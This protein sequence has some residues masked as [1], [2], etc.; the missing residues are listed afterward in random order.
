MSA[1]PVE[2]TPGACEP[3]AEAVL[4]RGG[5]ARSAA[6]PPG[7][8]ADAADAVEQVAGYLLRYGVILAAAIIV[9]GMALLLRQAG[10]LPYGA[11]PVPRSAGEVARGVVRLEPAALVDL[12]LGVLILTPVAR[13][14]TS[15]V[16]FALQRDHPYTIMGV[17]V[18][19]ILITGFL[20]GAT[21]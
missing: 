12:G 20:L 15:I 2:H 10:G 14:V 19:L 16:G 4:E 13:V 1:R 6:E 17:L 7:R 3:G 5:A 8:A 21:E 11:L 9:L 18:L